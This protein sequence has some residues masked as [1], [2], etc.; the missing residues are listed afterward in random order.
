MTMHRLLAR[1]FRKYLGEVEWAEQ[2]ALRQLFEAIAMSYNE[3]EAEIKLLQRATNLIDQE[4]YDMTRNLLAEKELRDQSVNTLLQAIAAIDESG[5][6]H[7]DLDS[8]NLLVIAEYLR[9]QID[10]RKE[11]EENIIERERRFQSV[12][13][14]MPGLTYRCELR[15]G[16][17]T[18]SF[19]NDE[20]KNLCGL[21]A[22]DFLSQPIE[23]WT[24]ILHDE[25]QEL[26]RNLWLQEPYDGAR[27]RMEYR[28][29]QADDSV[30]WVEERRHIVRDDTHRMVCVDGF[31]MD[32][33]ERKKLDL[34]LLSAKEAAESASRAKS[35][36][37]ANMSHEIR[38]PLNGVIGF[39]DILTK[40]RL[41]ETQMKYMHTIHL[42]ANN[43]LS[44][45]NNIL[46]FSKIEARRVEIVNE[47]C[48]ILDLCANV[49]DVV[50]FQVQQKQLA[51]HLHIAPD[52]P[53]FVWLDEHHI[54]QVLIN[55]LGNA[56]K[57]TEKGEI[58]LGL[59]FTE[60]GGELPAT[61]NF[62]VRDTGIGIDERNRKKIFGAFA[63]EDSSTT[64]RYGGTGLG[65]AISNRL[66]HLMGC[67]LDVQSELR[68]GSSFAFALPIEHFERAEETLQSSFVDRR[69]L[70][71]DSNKA[72]RT[73]LQSALT[74]SSI[75]CHIAESSA[76]ALQLL[77]E[78]FDFDAIV[79]N[80]ES[81]NDDAQKTI[82]RIRTKLHL[83][84]EQLPVIISYK[85]GD[86]S[87]V[88]SLC[89]E[90]GI[91]HR[92]T[93]PLSASDLMNMLQVLWSSNTELPQRAIN[94]TERMHV[95]KHAQSSPLLNGRSA[96]QQ[97]TSYSSAAAQPSSAHPALSILI[98]EDQPVNMMLMTT[99]L[100]ELLPDAEVVE[101]T[102]GVDA[103][104]HFM[105]RR[106]SLVFM[107]IQMPDLNGY[108]TTRVMRSYEQES[109]VPIIALT[110]SAVSG[111]REK[112]LQA[113]MDDYLTKPVVRENIARMLSKY[114]GVPKA[115][116]VT[117]EL[118]HRAVDQRVHFDR[119]D[120]YRRMGKHASQ[121]LVK[122]IPII[123]S[124]LDADLKTL[125]MFFKQE[126]LVG[127]TSI[128]HKL[129]GG[130]QS[131]SLTG[132]VEICQQLQ[133]LEHFDYDHIL[134]LIQQLE[135]EVQ[136]VKHSLELELN[137]LSL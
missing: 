27:R 30:I 75:E 25:D 48:D 56:T 76:E 19:M 36:F 3:Y 43:L 34:E 95:H 37:L 60:A 136:S 63:Q 31:I 64:K 12:V 128:G 74:I 23:C 83:N 4:Y 113:G 105:R 8:Q 69:V 89:K 98:A 81:T 47:R 7:A 96:D 67:S 50:S 79:I 94:S 46:D 58:A 112:C 104:A 101:T 121:M 39:A 11:A 109:H 66:L 62:L 125:T 45:I 52:V 129:K 21:E 51:L 126:N 124:S 61:L 55:L 1:Q 103:V 68:K 106:P 80:Y 28:V 91:R 13:S 72:E 97:G 18:F 116:G 102:N 132:M 88:T 127:I 35:E 9:T 130:S 40:T 32:I 123:N 5:S 38:T 41:D 117:K 82:S 77:L 131:M 78:N 122:T 85:V 107:D 20:V 6:F 49:M 24:E 10:R 115:T 53:R 33:T 111:E 54:R 70:I 114:L 59:S 22:D 90:F 135:L 99:I 44:I 108:E 133:E 110:A 87:A 120:F 26:Y 137:A 65:L 73:V 17:W 71:L 2:P 57:F 15:D 92:L 42:S 93:Q 86:E 100:G 14:N 29:R 84:D 119:K 134:N 16:V 118:V